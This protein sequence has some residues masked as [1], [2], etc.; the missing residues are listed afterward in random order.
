MEEYT[1]TT[2][3][4]CDM[5]GKPKPQN[6]KIVSC[7]EAQNLSNAILYLFSCRELPD[8]SG[9]FAAPMLFHAI[10]FCGILKVPDMRSRHVGNFPDTKK[11]CFHLRILKISFL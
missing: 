4:G 10:S 1:T 7:R 3:V 9:T 6:D 11:R 8:M 2:R 5:S